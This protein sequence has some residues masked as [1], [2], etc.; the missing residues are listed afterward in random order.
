MSEKRLF[1]YDG[2][3]PFCNHFAQLIELKS[4]LPEFE[5]L[6]GRN[7]LALLTQ[8]YNQGYD[9]NKGAILINGEKIMHG[10]DAVNWICS[11]IK[12]PSD[13]LL[14][15][16]R[17]IFTSNKMTNLLF[18]FLLWGR[19]LSLTLKGKVWRPVGENSQFF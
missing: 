4:S 19:R 18:P 11:E 9:L 3:C 16:L 10:A 1:I 15:V 12:E 14:E 2:E 13:S 17:I 7:N 8:L 5:I 6:D